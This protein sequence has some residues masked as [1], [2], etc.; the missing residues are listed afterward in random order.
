[1]LLKTKH[2]HPKDL[3]KALAFL[4]SNLW[5]TPTAKEASNAGSFVSSFLSMQLASAI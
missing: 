1:M 2:E 3:V 5:L 4:I